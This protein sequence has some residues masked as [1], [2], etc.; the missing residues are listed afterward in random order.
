MNVFETLGLDV[1]PVINASGVSTFYCGASML[2]EVIDAMA[3]VAKDNTAVRM[4]ELQGAAS[5]FIA[6]ITGAEAGYVTN[7]CAAALIAATAACLTGYDVARIDRLPDTSGI[8]NEVV[9]AACQRSGYWHCFTAT[10]AKVVSVGPLI[11]QLPPEVKDYEGAITDRTVAI[12]YFIEGG[13][14]PPLEEVVQLGKKYNVP[15][16]LDAANMVPPVE[17]LRKF[18]SMGVDLVAISGGK[19]IHGPQNS[20][21]LFG[22]RDLI[23]AAA[24]NYFV[25]GFQA[26]YVHYDQWDPAPSL[27]TK[28]KM[29]AIP[30]HPLGRGMKISRE[31]IVGLITALKILVEDEESPP[32]EMKRRRALLEPIVERLQQVSKVKSGIEFIRG[33]FGGF[34]ALIVKIDES[35]LGRSAR[36]VVQCLKEREPRIYVSEQRLFAGQFRITSSSMEEGDVKIVANRLYEAITGE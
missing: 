25:P 1:K 2:P 12:G 22:N 19:G 35:K 14:T 32:K 31:T 17:N 29:R 20:G 10:G 26:G 27:V 5:K 13:G 34:P 11:D 4:D 3:K 36:E 7:G 6:K 28:E 8:P 24:L 33:E 16:I 18:V 23:A 21:L 30:Q 15:I 9:I